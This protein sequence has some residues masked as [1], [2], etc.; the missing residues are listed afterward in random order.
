MKLA[1]FDQDTR[2]NYLPHVIEPAAGLTRGVLALLCE[3]Y[4]AD[5]NRPSGVYMKFHPRMAPIKAAVFPLVNKEGMPE[6]AREAV[7]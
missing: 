7:R 2:E 3:A 6:V 4:T 5:P 1:Y